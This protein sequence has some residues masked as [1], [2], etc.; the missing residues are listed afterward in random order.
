M[1]SEHILTNTAI[2]D[3]AKEG[4]FVAEPI[5]TRIVAPDPA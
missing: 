3:P 4:G 1:K 2:F 5:I